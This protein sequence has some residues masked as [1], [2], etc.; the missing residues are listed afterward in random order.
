MTSSQDVFILKGREMAKI[1]PNKEQKTIF[2][3]M[4]KVLGGHV[5]RVSFSGGGDSG[6]INDAELLDANMN[7]ISMDGITFEWTTTTDQWVDAV[8]E[9]KQTDALGRTG[10]WK[11]VTITETLPIADILKN[12]TEQMLEYEGLDWYNNEGGQG[13]LDILLYT[14]PPTITLNVGI[15][16][17]VTHDHEFDYTDD[18]EDETVI[19]EDK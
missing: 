14:T 2:L 3:N 11:T 19:G 4:L 16:E 12:V 15:N 6:E 5:A 8:G 13:S 9:G 17:V 18:D 10:S 7:H 1:F